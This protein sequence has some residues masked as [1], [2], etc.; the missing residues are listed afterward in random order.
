MP[1]RI[2]RMWIFYVVAVRFCKQ[3]QRNEQRII[4]HAY[5]VIVLVAVVVDLRLIKLP[6][7]E[8]KRQ[9]SRFSCDIIVFRK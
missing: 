4:T 8:L 9:N 3:R 2:C 5:S 1:F 6:K 7:T